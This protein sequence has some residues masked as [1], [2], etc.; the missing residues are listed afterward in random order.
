MTTVVCV[1]LCVNGKSFVTKIVFV[2][3]NVSVV[4]ALVV[5]A[6]EVVRVVV[7]RVRIEVEVSRS[8]RVQVRSTRRVD[9]GLVVR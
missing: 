3:R 1:A 7:M 6:V 9:A 4:P 2:V 8:V 5:Y